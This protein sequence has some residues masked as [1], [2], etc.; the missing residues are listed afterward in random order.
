MSDLRRLKEDNFPNSSKLSP[1]IVPPTNS[2]PSTSRATKSAGGLPSNVGFSKGPSTRLCYKQ[3]HQSS[4]QPQTDQQAQFDSSANGSLMNTSKTSD[5]M[6]RY[7]FN[8]Y[9]SI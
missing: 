6:F 3:Q 2:Q 5:S 7:F 8:I 1:R 4:I 9:L